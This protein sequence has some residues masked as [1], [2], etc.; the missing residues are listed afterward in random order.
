MVVSI[1]VLLL[2]MLTGVLTARYLGPSGRGEQ[3]AMVLW[4]QFLS[5]SLTFGVPSALIYNAKKYPK[6]E[7]EM[8][9]TALCMGFATGLIAMTAGLL[10]LPHWLGSFSDSVVLFSQLSMLLCPIIAVSQVNY[11]ILQVR[12]EYK[13]YNLLRYLTPSATLLVLVLLIVFGAMNP[14][15][16]AM[17]YLLPSMPIYIFMTVKL[18][19][20]YKKSI[21]KVGQS[22]KRLL[23]Y[24]MGSYGN[25]LMGHFSYY[26]DQIL[27]AGML[28]PADLGLYAVAVSLSRMV[29]VFSTSTIVVLFPKA[30]GLPEQEAIKLAFRTFRISTTAA[31]AASFV[32]MLMA[33]YVFELLYGSEFHRA[34]SAFRVLLLEVAIGGGTMVLAQVFMAVGKPK[35]VTLLQSVGLALVIPMIILLVPRYGLLGAGIAM[36]SSVLLRFSFILINVKVTLK[37]KVPSLLI[38]REDI[39]WL[40]D[41]WKSYSGNRRLKPAAPFEREDSNETPVS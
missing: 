17:A 21:K 30:S 6:N 15:T 20:I 16:T 24:G 25:D 32:L 11:A 12:G 31:L 10:V 34:L 38:T 13:Y 3:T 23:Y 39:S 9:V 35:I 5:F 2:N 1:L 33:P 40:K 41:A 4:S 29:N 14:Y 8:Y 27:I 7:G 22:F 36:L 19:R 26:I 37:T 18:L 28:S